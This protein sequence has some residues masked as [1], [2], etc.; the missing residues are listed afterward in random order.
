[1]DSK[2]NLGREHTAALIGKQLTILVAWIFAISV[3]IYLFIYEPG[4]SG[5]FPE[6]PF[7]ALTGIICPGCG[8]TR[9]LHHLLHGN[10]ETAL[11]L[12]PLMF[13]LLPVLLYTLVRHTKAAVTGEVL[14]GNRVP[15][16]YIWALFG[17]ILFFWIVRNVPGYPFPV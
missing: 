16:H 3:V 17:V 2:F 14:R 1:M 8:S 7:R 10:V 11:L 15:A 4:R 5:F 9:A 12:N 13:L 6:C